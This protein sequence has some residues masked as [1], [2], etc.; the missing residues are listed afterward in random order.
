MERR[1]QEFELQTSAV[2]DIQNQLKQ[3]Q[4]Q[5]NVQESKENEQL[6]NQLTTLSSRMAT[7]NVKE[8]LSSSTPDSLSDY[9]HQSKNDKR[10]SLAEELDAT[11]NELKEAEDKLTAAIQQVYLS[12][13][14][15]VPA[16]NL[17]A[18]NLGRMTRQIQSFPINPSTPILT[19]L[20]NQVIK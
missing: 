10:L 9:E 4:Q 5:I 3:L 12:Y 11:Q 6:R 18:D 16:Y 19:C 2:Q 15:I 8:E 7:I 20:T 13:K 14:P 17:N 1:L